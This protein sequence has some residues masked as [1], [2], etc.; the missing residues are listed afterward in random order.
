MPSLH[1][2][3]GFTGSGKTTFARKLEQELPAFRFSPDEWMVQLYGHNPPAEHFPEYFDRVVGLIWQ[4]AVRLL[5]LGVDVVLD[6]GFWSRSS[7]DEAR[8]RAA[9]LGI[10]YRLYALSCSEETMRRR[11]LRRTADLP[12]D[13]LWINAEAFE[14]FKSRFEPLA[15]D[16]EHVRIDTDG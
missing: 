12:A 7:R 3:H 14:L 5:E 2:L 9:V 8:A 15:Q 16:E 1:L 13:A 10:P 4:S 6:F 11:V